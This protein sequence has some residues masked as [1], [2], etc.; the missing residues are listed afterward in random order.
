MAALLGDS[1]ILSKLDAD[2]R[3]NEIF[4]HSGLEF[5]WIIIAAR[6]LNNVGKYTYLIILVKPCK[7]RYI[8]TKKL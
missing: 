7:C 4:Y 1:T 5:I 3:A 8:F 2:V 6:F